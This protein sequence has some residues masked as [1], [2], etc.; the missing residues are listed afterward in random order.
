VGDVETVDA[1]TGEVTE[2]KA[3]VIL[4]PSP[5][6]A[7][8]SGVE[9]SQ[10]CERVRASLMDET[11]ALE[12]L[13][14][15][16]HMIES[17]VKLLGKWWRSVEAALVARMQTKNAT[18]V[19]DPRKG[20]ALSL[21]QEHEYTYDEAALKGLLDLVGVPDGLSMAKYE[22][23]MGYKFNPSKTALNNLQKRGGKVAEIINLGVRDNPKY[24]LELKGGDRK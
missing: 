19:G 13:P 17:K 16:V 5:L 8:R 6:F 18:L 4:D 9:L 1:E 3:V 15:D 11:R 2:T 24:K 21:K 22:G 7:E 14:A 20:P 10:A 12:T 23:A